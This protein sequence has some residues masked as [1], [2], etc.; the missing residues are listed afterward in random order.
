MSYTKEIRYFRDEP[1][2]DKWEK[3]GTPGSKNWCWINNMIEERYVLKTEPLPP[4]FS[5]GRVKV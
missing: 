4:G 3:V 2:L 5:R 1:N